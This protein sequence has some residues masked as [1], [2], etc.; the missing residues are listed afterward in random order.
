MEQHSSAHAEHSHPTPGLYLKIAVVLFALTALEVLAF[1]AGR[2][3]FG[4]SS[5]SIFEPIVV[6]LLVV[7][8]GAKFILVAMFYMHLKQDP[9]L[10]SNLFIWPLVIA[11]GLLAALIILLSY[12]RVVGSM[13]AP[14]AA[15]H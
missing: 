9:K 5:Q 13:A 7:L 15:L 10:L 1:E 8:S 2:G 12:W 6:L 4:A 14:N 11:A 3:S